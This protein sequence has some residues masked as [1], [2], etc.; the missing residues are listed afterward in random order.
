MN[1]DLIILGSHP[2]TDIGIDILKKA[3]LSLNEHFDILLATHYPVDKEIQFLVKYFIYDQRNEFLKNDSIHFW[4]DYPNFYSEI[5]NYQSDEHHSFAVLQNIINGINFSDTTYEDFYYLEGDCRF[6]AKD[7]SLLKEMKTKSIEQNKKACFFVFPN[8]ISTAA[9][10]SNTKFFKENIKFCKNVEEYDLYC[11]EIDSFGITENYLYTNIK[12]NKSF[13]D[14]L[15]LDNIHPTDH[16]PNSLLGLNS[17]SCVSTGETLYYKSFTAEVVKIENEN[18]IALIYLNH[19]E[20]VYKEDIEIYIDDELISVIPS[21]KYVSYYKINPKN[22]NFTI[23]IGK[24]TLRRNKEEIL[25]S[26]SFLRIK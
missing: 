5:Y 10:Y 22:N 19:N 8:F 26:N 6:D 9:F 21:G 18:S 14:V 12:Y 2:N 17:V 3:I 7:I 4:L 1:K 13:D 11:K 24:V 20:N 23:K 15:I 25:K 16:F